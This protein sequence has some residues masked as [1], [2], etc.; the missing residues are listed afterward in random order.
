[1]SVFRWFTT[2]DEHKNTHTYHKGQCEKEK[3]KKRHIS[4][5]NF[6]ASKHQSIYITIS[7]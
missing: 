3:E 1:M 5:L 6:Q 2:E 7:H 4:P